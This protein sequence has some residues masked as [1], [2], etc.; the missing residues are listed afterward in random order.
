MGI[1][2]DILHDV[3]YGL[4]MLARTPGFAVAAVVTLGLGIGASTA[5]FTVVNA[6]ILR[7]LPYPDPDRLVYVKEDLGPGGVNPL[8]TSREFLA[9]KNQSRTLS[10]LAGY[11]SSGANLT[12]GDRSERVITGKVTASFFPLLGAQPVVGRSFLPEEDRPDGPPAAILSHALWQ[13]RFGGD[14]SR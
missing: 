3:R 14:R 9:W 4:R 5:I 6:V 11:I 7:P 12:G 2:Q 10:H 13:R 1:L 8:V